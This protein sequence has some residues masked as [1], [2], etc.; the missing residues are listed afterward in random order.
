MILLQVLMISQE[1]SAVKNGKRE[2]LFKNIDNEKKT[3]ARKSW[4]DDK[5]WLF[6]PNNFR[7]AHGINVKFVCGRLINLKSHKSFHFIDF[8]LP[9][10]LSMRIW[11]FVFP[12]EI[13]KR[14]IFC[15]ISLLYE[16]KRCRLRKEMQLSALC[17]FCGSFHNGTRPSKF[18]SWKDLEK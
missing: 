4:P 18:I 7:A 17:L 8:W 9:E 2:G 16:I 15:T 3:A 1:K 10:T 14:V 6:L 5:V 12:V 11:I 13:P